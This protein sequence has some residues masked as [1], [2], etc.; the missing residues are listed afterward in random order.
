M[1]MP[2]EKFDRVMEAAQRQNLKV[3]LR[4]GYTRDYYSGDNVLERYEKLLYDDGTKRAWIQYAKRLY[5]EQQF[6]KISAAALSHGK[7]SGI[8]QKTAFLRK[9]VSRK[10]NGFKMRLH[11]VCKRTLY[12]RRTGRN[13]SGIPL[14]HMRMYICRTV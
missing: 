7:I 3:M 13:V 10:E 11:P 12:I 9:R 6:M 2:G 14:K 8:L 1:T 5:E 4:V